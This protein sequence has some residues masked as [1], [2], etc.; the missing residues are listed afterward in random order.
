MVFGNSFREMGIDS[1]LNKKENK[2]ERNLGS[3]GK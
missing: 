2:I 1:T 3:E